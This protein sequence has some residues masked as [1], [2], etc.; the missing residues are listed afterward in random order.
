MPANSQNGL[1]QRRRCESLVMGRGVFRWVARF[2]ESYGLCQARFVGLGG[3]PVLATED[4][5]APL[6]MAFLFKRG[7]NGGRDPMKLRC[8]VVS[9]CVFGAFSPLVRAEATI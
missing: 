8:L 2:S 1:R 7:D 9:L 5:R 4:C 3:L 6:V